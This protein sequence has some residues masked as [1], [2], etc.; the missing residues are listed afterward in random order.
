M[1]AQAWTGAPPPRRHAAASCAPSPRT[2]CCARPCRALRV[3]VDEVSVRQG[4]MAGKAKRQ[5]H[6]LFAAS[7]CVCD[8]N[9]VR[10]GRDLISASCSSRLLALV[11][12]MLPRRNCTSGAGGCDSSALAGRGGAGRGGASPRGET[13]ASDTHLLLFALLLVHSLDL[14]LE[15]TERLCRSRDRLGRERALLDRLRRGV[16]HGELDELAVRLA[17]EGEGAARCVEAGQV[18]G[19]RMKGGK[20]RRRGRTGPC[21]LHAPCGRRG[22]GRSRSTLASRS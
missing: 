4:A 18:G 16:L 9:Q 20:G 22:G 1:D 2:C 12:S 7:F 11:S 8:W 21:G 10:A 19:R 3:C 5:Q 13:P 14:G 6:A 15:R 17:D